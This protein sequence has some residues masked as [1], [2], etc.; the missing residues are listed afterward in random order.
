MPEFLGRVIAEHAGDL[1]S[2]DALSDDGILRVT[3]VA[4][5]LGGNHLVEHGDD[6]VDVRRVRWSNRPL[7]QVLPGFVANASDV[8]DKSIGHDISPECRGGSPVVSLYGNR[9]QVRPDI[10]R[11]S[12]PTPSSRQCPRGRISKRRRRP[13]T[14]RPA[15]QALSTARAGCG[16]VAR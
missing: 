5:H 9:R 6:L 11:A 1:L 8:D 12:G 14:R 2:V 10:A 3:Q 15:R 13:A 7:F 16:R 4:H